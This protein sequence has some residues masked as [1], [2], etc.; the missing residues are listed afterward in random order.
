MSDNSQTN[1]DEAIAQSEDLLVNGGIPVT[2]SKK[3]IHQREADE[4]LF[5]RFLEL[6]AIDQSHN[7]IG[8]TPYT[9][10]KQLSR[11]ADKGFGFSV[12]WTHPPRIEKVEAGLSADLNDIQS[13]DYVIFV[14]KHNV[15]TMPEADILNL[16][17]AQ[18][19][20]LT[21]E[22]CRRTT[23]TTTTTAVAAAAAASVMPSEFLAPKPMTNPL[24]ASLPMTACSNVSMALEANKQKLHIPQVTFS[25]EVGCGVIV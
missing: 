25:K 12:V 23:A 22:I 15:V 6:A 11:T 5:L 1:V 18:G 19:N 24:A 9:M 7:P 20:S 16:I 10:T 21:L 4:N 3:A 14:D 2:L 8:R 13:G 17:K